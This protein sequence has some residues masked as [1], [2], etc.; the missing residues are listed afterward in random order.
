M[1]C[2]KCKLQESSVIDSRY[3]KRKNGIRRRRS[4]SNCSYRFTTYEHINSFKIMVVK[5]SNY[6]EQFDI[7]KIEKSFHIACK[8]RPVSEE[9]IQKLLNQIEEKIH[10][11]YSLEVPSSIIGQIVMDM[12]ISVD[13]VAFIRYAS[14]YRQFDDL[15]EFKKQ[16]KDIEKS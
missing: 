8:K 13:E 5:K 15:G 1:K 2:P 7:K 12:L 6:R 16:I 3:I 14:V 9:L 4:C 10:K 11:N